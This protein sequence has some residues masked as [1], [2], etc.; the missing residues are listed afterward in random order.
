MPDRKELLKREVWQ[1]FKTMQ[2]VYL[3]TVENE[4]PRVRPVTMLFLENRFWILTGTADDKVTHLRSNPQTEFCLPLPEDRGTGYVRFSGIAIIVSDK[5]TKVRIA[6]NCPYFRDHWQ[7]TNDPQFTLLEIKAAG[8]DYLK[9]G[10]YLSQ[11][12]TV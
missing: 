2:T 3:G 9:P 7:D 10:E 4:Q 6:E 8:I 11:K 1:R 5:Q 12:L